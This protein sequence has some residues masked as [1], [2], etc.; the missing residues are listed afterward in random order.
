MISSVP[1][2]SLSIVSHGQ[3]NLVRSLIEDLIKLHPDCIEVIVTLNTPEDYSSFESSPFPIRFIHNDA[4]KGFGANHNFAFK[5]ALGRYFVVVNPDIRLIQWDSEELLRS[6][7]N[8]EVGVVGPIVVNHSGDIEDSVRLFPTFTRLLRRRFF[9]HRS[10]DYH[11]GSEPFSVDWVAGMFMVFNMD[12]YHQVNGF[13]EKRFFMYLEDAD[14]CRRLWEGG[15]AV[16]ANP[17]IKVIHSAQRASRRNLKHF[18]WHLVS[19]MRYLTG[20]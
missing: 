5:Q 3:F 4:P 11:W 14:V 17:R 6:M 7:Q 2:F 10:P 16:L 20:L 13:D 12:A 9:K 18:R 19:A 15:W 8:P 1:V